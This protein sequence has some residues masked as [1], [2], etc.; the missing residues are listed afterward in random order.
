MAEGTVSQSSVLDAFAGAIAGAMYRQAQ[1]QPSRS[2]SDLS[3]STRANA[4]AT[5]FD[6]AS[7]L[8][9]NPPNPPKKTKFTPP[10]LFENKRNRRPSRSRVSVE[11]PI[12]VTLYVRDIILLPL[13]YKPVPNDDEWGKALLFPE[14][15]AELN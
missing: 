7:Q 13:E 2:D 6:R 11:K 10:T 14:N 4:N 15:R 3:P 8:R 9:I 5:T 1:S 12:K